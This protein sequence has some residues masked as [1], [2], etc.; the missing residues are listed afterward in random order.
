MFI[1]LATKYI[2]AWYTDKMDLTYF[3]AL[4]HSIIYLLVIFALLFTLALW[5]GRY[6][7]INLILSLNL[8]LLL[9]IK[10]PYLETMTALTTQTYA[11]FIKIIIFLFFVAGSYY[12]FRRHI[13]GDDYEKIFAN[14][15]QKIL[16]TLVATFL[17]IMISQQI[18]SFDGLMSLPESL[19]TLLDSKT[20]FFWL[21]I[22]SLL[23]LFVV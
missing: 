9:F 20:S 5:R 18:F 1:V 22:L 3:L 7:L 23:L 6:L 11:V 17:I 14:L 12:I 4:L 2:S 19:Q 16:L 21:L 8:A 13:P 15:W 10:F